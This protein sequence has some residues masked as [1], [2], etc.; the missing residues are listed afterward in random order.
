MHIHHLKIENVKSFGSESRA[1]DLDLDR[2]DG[3]P[4]GWTVVAGR[5]GAGKSTFLQAIAMVLA[6]PEAAR[7]LSKDWLTWVRH[8]AKGAQVEAGIRV[9]ESDNFIGGGR[10]VS[11]SFWSGLGWKVTSEGPVPVMSPLRIKSSSVRTSERGPWAENPAGWLI[12]AYGPFRRVSNASYE[13]LQMMKGPGHVPRLVSLFREDASLAESVSWLESIYLRRLENRPGWAD[14]E[15]D[16]IRLMNDGLLPQGF[17]I[18]RIDSDGLWV[19]HEQIDLRLEA[20]SDGYRT[21][22]ALILDIARHIHTTYGSLDLAARDG[23]DGAVAVPHP[24]VVLIDE[25]DAHLHV[26]W[27]QSIGPWLKTHFPNVQFIVSTHSP[28]I[29]QAADPNGLIRLPAP[30][31]DRP[32]EHVTGELFQ[33]ITRGSADE[34]IMTELFGLEHTHSDESELLRRRLAEVEARVLG[35]ETPSDDDIR[36]LSLLRDELPRVG[37]AAVDQA[38]R[39][40]HA[41]ARDTQ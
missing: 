20:V 13:A 23:S 34:A 27:Q 3:S 36:Q 10:T 41:V 18:D 7:T 38:W 15:R 4:A 6:G 21:V 29:C 2:P 40:L 39:L 24:G 14:L 12:A 1:V 35:V 30:G 37:P 17:V 5:N 28:F 33:E 8:G 19:R 22:A 25:I 9:H 16:V 32:A 11:K 26:S 31:E